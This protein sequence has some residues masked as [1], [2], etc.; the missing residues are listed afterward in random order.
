MPRTR[1]A[2]GKVPRA[3]TAATAVRKIKAIVFDM[4]EPLEDAS[5]YAHAL[6]LI[7]LGMMGA[8]P[9]QDERAIVAIA[10]A[11]A[12]RLET[13]DRRWNAILN[14]IRATRRTKRRLG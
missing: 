6:M 11:A 7:G 2:P 8:G 13:V 10:S 5:N 14:A 9:N 4:E 3:P 12:D 1:P